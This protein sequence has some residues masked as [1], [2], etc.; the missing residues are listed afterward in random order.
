MSMLPAER[1]YFF[2]HPDC[3]TTTGPHCIEDCDKREDGRYQSCRGCDIYA[4][5]KS[6]YFKDNIP[7][8]FVEGKPTFWNHDGNICTPWE[9]LLCSLGD[10]KIG[11]TKVKLKNKQHKI[12]QQLFS[13]EIIELHKH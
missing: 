9:H 12:A 8:P 13:L 11:K 2:I 6:G 1:L 10:V 5:C 3:K 4:E 7:C